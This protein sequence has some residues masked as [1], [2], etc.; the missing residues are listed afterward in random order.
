MSVPAPP[1]DGRHFDRAASPWNLPEPGWYYGYPL[2]LLMTLMV[3]GMLAYFRRRLVAQLAPRLPLL[4][5][6][7]VQETQT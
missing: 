7:R 2:A 1:A 3:L 4:Q 6:N 5:A